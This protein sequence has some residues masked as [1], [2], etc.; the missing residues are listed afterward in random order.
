MGNANEE[1]H[2]E[3]LI[4]FK[5][6][7][8]FYLKCLVVQCLFPMKKKNSMEGIFNGHFLQENHHTI[9]PNPTEKSRD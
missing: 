5:F 9:M 6:S 8:F 3:F 1:F 7:V 2:L 4:F